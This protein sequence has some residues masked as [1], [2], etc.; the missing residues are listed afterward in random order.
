[1]KDVSNTL[2]AWELPTKENGLKEAKLINEINLPDIGTVATMS[3]RFNE[4]NFFYNFGG[5]T[6][7]GGIHSVDF[8]SKNLK[9][10]LL[11]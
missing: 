9:Q 7:P 5:L 11:W 6:N 2:K 10:D 3:G 4:S 8:T 1:M